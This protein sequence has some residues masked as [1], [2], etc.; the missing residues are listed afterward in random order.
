MDVL[1]VQGLILYKCEGLH[2]LELSLAVKTSFITKLTRNS[3]RR[4]YYAIN[5]KHA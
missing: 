3:L 2:L 5:V 4:I 1:L